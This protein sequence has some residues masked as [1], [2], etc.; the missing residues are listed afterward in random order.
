M[1]FNDILGQD[2]PLSLLKSY[3]EKSRLDGSYLFTGPDGVGKKLVA[4]TLSKAVNCLESEA[5]PCDRCVS[6]L[7]I[8]KDEHPDVYAIDCDTPILIDSQS[9]NEKAASEAIK[10]G[11][12]R[13]LQKNIA[14]KPYEGKKKVFIIDSAHNLTPEASNAFLKILEEPVEKSLIILITSKPFLLFK[15]IISRCK[16]LKF[17]GLPR[18]ALEKIIKKDFGFDNDSAHFLAYFSEGRLGRAF[19]LK[20]TDLLREKNMVIDSFALSHR[21]NLDNINIKKREDVRGYLNILSTWFRDIYLIKA[22]LTIQEIINYDR[23]DELL[24]QMSRFTFAELDGILN[25]IS[26]SIFYLERN[27]NTRLLLHN[28]GAK[29]WKG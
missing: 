14:L 10:I 15:T 17:S 26:D 4:K 27:I 16:V 8:N 3:I 1:S 23:R 11:H 9:G 28:L 22:G 24:K 20:D 19:V 6:C 25:S 12:I 18:P 29:L 21:V 2:G 7:K 13:Q 5:S